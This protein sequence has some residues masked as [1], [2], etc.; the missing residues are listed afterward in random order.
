VSTILDA[1]KKASEEQGHVRSPIAQGELFS[2]TRSTQSRPDRSG[3]SFPGVTH[4]AIAVGMLILIAAVFIVI[5]VWASN[6]AGRSGEAATGPVASPAPQPAVTPPTPPAPQAPLPTTVAAAVPTV[7]P[8]DLAPP[9]QTQPPASRIDRYMQTQRGSVPVP[10]PLQIETLPPPDQ[11]AS[12]ERDWDSE[13]DDAEITE[14]EP[15][16]PQQPEFR[17]EGIVYDENNP[18]AIVNGAIV[19]PGDS[20]G[21]AQ[22][23]AISIESVTLSVRGEEIILAH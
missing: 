10:I 14:I 17:L 22:V 12:L 2:Q 3:S 6:T 4:A 7:T 1:L 23:V 18:M 20:V 13:L 15:P 11:L 9:R 19:S 5:V 21:G 8:G 16:A